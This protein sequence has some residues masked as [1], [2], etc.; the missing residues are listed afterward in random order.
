[1]PLRAPLA[2]VLRLLRSSR[3]LS[4]EDFQGVIETRHIHNLEH[5]KSS[6]TLDTLEK[7]AAVLE[8]DPVALL[9]IASSYERGMT[10]KDYVKQ[11][12]SEVTKLEKLGVIDKM[13][14]EFEDGQLV[15][16]Q[17]GKRSSTE[18]RTAILN[19]KAEGRSQKETSEL[20]GLAKSTVS[21]VWNQ[22]T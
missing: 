22:G 8:V 20:L 7:L 16:L 17:P 11:I 14:G 15:T 5:G 4:Q 18:N 3:G 12:A 6:V 21:R 2:A 9:A 1:M 13:L 19:C 10:A